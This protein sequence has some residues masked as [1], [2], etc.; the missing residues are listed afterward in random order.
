MPDFIEG[1]FPKIKFSSKD[2]IA[3]YV[4]SVLSERLKDV[5]P[6]AGANIES[7]AVNVIEDLQR[8]AFTAEKDGSVLRSTFDSKINLAVDLSKRAI[9]DA[10]ERAEIAAR[11]TARAAQKS[12]GNSGASSERPPRRALLAGVVALGGVGLIHGAVVAATA[13]DKDTGERDWGRTALHSAEAV[14][15]AGITWAAIA[16]IRGKGPITR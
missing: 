10:A 7:F 6:V 5:T 4:R 3:S 15:G 8:R 1:E 13:V 9:V 12:P 11:R 14:I 2:E 16:A